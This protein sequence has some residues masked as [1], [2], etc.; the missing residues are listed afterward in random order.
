MSSY[1]LPFLLSNSALTH[2]LC[3]LFLLLLFVLLYLASLHSSTLILLLDLPPP[4]PSP[5]LLIIFPLALLF[6]PTSSSP[7]FVTSIACPP[8]LLLSLSLVLP[9]LSPSPRHSVSLHLFLISSYIS[10]FPFSVI[11]HISPLS[12]SLLLIFSFSTSHFPSLHYTCPSFHPTFLASL[13]LSFATI[14]VFLFLLILSLVLCLL[15]RL[16]LH[17]L[18]TPPLS[19]PPPKFILLHDLHH[20]LLLLCY[21]C[22]CLPSSSRPFYPSSVLPASTLTQSID[23]A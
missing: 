6:S 19:P 4:L 9:L 2:L 11:C 23:T 18:S 12:Y 13:S 8:H 5:R 3:F 21:Y 20:F 7:H 14:L 10:C 15:V 22:A 1:C 16:L 17:I